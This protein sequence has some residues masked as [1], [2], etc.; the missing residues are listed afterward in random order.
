MEK[1]RPLLRGELLE[2]KA[3]KNK[4]KVF[5]YFEDKK[6]T[7]KE[8]NDI[9]NRVANGFLKLGVQKRDN[10]CIMLPNCPEFL[11]TWFG[12]A[13]I[14]AVE[15]PVNIALKGDFLRYIIDNC[16]AKIMVIDNQFLERV[17]FIQDDLP[18]LE[19]LI[20]IGDEVEGM[21]FA[22]T[23]FGELLNNTADTPLIDI[24]PYDTE[25]IIY[26]SGTTGNPKGVMI[27]HGY[28]SQMAAANVKYRDLTSNDIVYT[29]LPL[30]HGNAQ[31]LTT[32]PCL[33][34]DAQLVLA[35]R[36]RA[37]Q[38]WDE[39]RKY[40]ATQFNFIGAML[41][42]IYKQP[43]KEDDADN[44]VRIAFGAP[45]PK[46]FCMDF[47]RRFNLR[48]V[49]PF[50]LTESGIICH[51][52]YDD[53]TKLGS[54]GKVSDGYEVKLVNDD[55][56]E[57]PTGEVGEII[58]RTTKPNFMMSGY[59]KMPEKTLEA[60]K[61]LWF[62]T[63]DYGRKDEDGYFYF[64][65]RKKDYLRV[66][67]ENISS[68]QI[69][70]AINSHPKITE[71]AALGVCSDVGEDEMLLYVVLKSGEQLKPEELLSFCEERIPRFAIPRFVEFID[72]LPK[73]PTERVE[74]YKLKERGLTPNT[75]DREKAGYKLKR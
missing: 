40:K 23:P 36:L 14:G 69:E 44:P 43:E 38:F 48:F 53:E 52:L 29:P 2:E 27:S 39:I 41:T 10:M 17:K 46:Q 37:T 11:Y 60:F 13:K 56:M 24:D 16:D 66:R 34:A 30:F 8:I 31:G 75:W 3:K 62:H 65:D 4:D 35:E 7:Y 73:T 51:N 47:K 20:I 19:R 57:M 71:S 58:S 70:A 28:Y 72:E 64:V 33:V 59:Y 49:E 61:N 9:A 54:F 21:K 26:T 25:A 12:L 55:D 15:V 32:I 5:L 22:S 42:F 45:T 67:G 74:K 6:V 63:G 68:M 1:Q 18:K 50:G